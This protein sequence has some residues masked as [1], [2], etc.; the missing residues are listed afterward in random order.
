MAT[1]SL[2]AL[3]IIF[4]IWI[5]DVLVALD[6]AYAILSGAIFVPVVLGIFWKK[7]TPKAGFSAVIGGTAVVIGGLAVLGITSTD[8]IMYG[9]AASLIIMVGVSLFDRSRPLRET[10]RPA[11][12]LEKS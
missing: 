10:T 7:A 3:A 8:P 9:M 1:L 4:A 11:E 12:Q 6:V 5:Q 2:G